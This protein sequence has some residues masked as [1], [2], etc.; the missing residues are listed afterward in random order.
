M[1]ILQISFVF[2]LLLTG[3]ESFAQSAATKT[4]KIVT[5]EFSV[6]GVCGMC[7]ARIEKAGLIKGVKL[8]SW[9][10]DAQKVKVIYSAKKTK[11][12]DI[13]RA[14]AGVGHDSD[15]VKAEEKDYKT[16]PDCC[17]YRDG[18]KVH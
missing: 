17:A 5:T 18:V 2:C 1:K 6:Q 12:E 9:D 15:L 16:L 4:S 14:I 8:V 7:Q 13:H 3:S 10:K 11:L